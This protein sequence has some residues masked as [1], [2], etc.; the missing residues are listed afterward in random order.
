M[1]LRGM[2]QESHLGCLCINHIIPLKN[3][4]CIN[5]KLCNLNHHEPPLKSL[6]ATTDPRL[7]VTNW[8]KLD[9]Q[10]WIS[11]IVVFRVLATHLNWNTFY[12]LKPINGSNLEP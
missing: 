7:Y 2:E 9:A 8:L 10:V 6:M 3:N 11:V 5:H 1:P 4:H 12:S